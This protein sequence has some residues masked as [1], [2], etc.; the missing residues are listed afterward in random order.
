MNS[1]QQIIKYKTNHNKFEIKHPNKVYPTNKQKTQETIKIHNLTKLPTRTQTNKLQHKVKFAQQINIKKTHSK[2]N[3]TMINTQTNKTQTNTFTKHDKGNEQTNKTNFKNKKPHTLDTH[4]KGGTLTLKSNKTGSAS[5]PRHKTKRK[6]LPQDKIIPALPNLST[7]KDYTINLNIIN[8]REQHKHYKIQTLQNQNTTNPITKHITHKNQTSKPL[9]NKQTKHYK[10]YRKTPDYRPRHKTQHTYYHTF[11]HN[12]NT[13]AKPT[14]KHTKLT[15]YLPIQVQKPIHALPNLFTTSK[16]I[17]LKYYK[18]TKRNPKIKQH[19]G[20]Q[21]NIQILKTYQNYKTNIIKIHL[22]LKTNKQQNKLHNLYTNTNKTKLTPTKSH[23]NNKSYVKNIQ[24]NKIIKNP[25]D[26][27]TYYLTKRHK[28]EHMASAYRPRQKIGNIRYIHYTTKSPQIN[29]PSHT[30]QY[31]NQTL[32]KTN[33]ICNT[34]TNT[35]QH[36]DSKLIQKITYKSLIKITNTPLTNPPTTK[37]ITN[38]LTNTEIKPKHAKSNNQANNPT[39]CTNATQHQKI[40]YTPKKI[41]FPTFPNTN[42]G[43]AYRPRHKI[44]T[45]YQLTNNWTHNTI[46]NHIPKNTRSIHFPIKQLA[47]SIPALPNL[48]STTKFTLIAYQKINMRKPKI[49]QLNG[50]YFANTLTLLICGDIEPNPGPMPDILCTHPAIHKKRAKTYFIPNTIK[51]QPEYQ[52]IASTFA[53]ILRHNHPLHHQ[54]II[55]YP[56][57][58]RYTQTQNHSPP[59]HIL[60]AVIITINPSIDTCNNILA[61]PHTYHFNDIWTNTLLIR[62][63]NLNNPPERHILTPHP[64][65]TF[66]ENNQ[67][68]INPSNSIHTELYEFIHSQNTPPT[69]LVIQEKFP[70]LPQKLITESLRCLENINEYSH[71]PP[72]LNISTPTPSTIT[73]TNHE[74]NIITWNAS[75]LNTALPNLQSLINQSFRN[76]AIIHIQETKLTATKSTKY[77]QNLFPEYKLIFNNTHALTRCIQQRMP[78]TPGRG[79]LLTLIHNK[80]AF[81]G[82]ITKIPTP[83]NI[84][85]Y[86]Q[87]IKI[88][89]HPLLPWLIIHMYMPTHLEDTHLI[90]C[91]KTEITNQI[92]TN[93]NHTHILCGDFNRDIALTGRLNNHNNT[94]PQAEDIQWKNFTTTLKL[95]YIPTN[96]NI[97][98]QGGYNYT[99]TSLIDG[100][101]INSSNNSTF[102]STINTDMNL[103]SDHYPVT[104]HIPQNILLARPPPPLILHQQEY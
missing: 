28:S 47:T 90:P 2:F 95:E 12:I 44:K 100:F 46:T 21:S 71:P 49:R 67:N 52:H 40:T 84:S 70:F 48:F 98:R 86:L 19:K 11:E 14:H 61:Q 33:T 51:L 17:L 36:K 54:T 83:A 13:N 101:Y 22:K 75:S 89:N 41:R 30:S 73:D 97:S 8:S 64:Y 53:P 93:P 77:I 57:I 102:T 80:Y 85:P 5:R 20:Y 35:S 59:T 91:L 103:N 81:P 66:V 23:T 94:P 7:H 45:K 29:Y 62:L 87:I 6:C 60:Y 37:Q 82:N 55:M 74:T 56:H 25:L 65:T 88:N 76:T 92:T 24:N 72:L 68:I 38:I 9:L 63:A 58:Y 32:H 15:H 42:T 27:N 69:P 79:G 78:Y 99:S 10:G 104:L 1:K 4:I 18:T 39:T 96:L 34:K 43:S 50:Y 16:Y 3:D 31:I 26:K